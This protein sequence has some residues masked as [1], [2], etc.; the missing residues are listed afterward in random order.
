MGKFLAILAVLL[1][2]IG[3]VGFLRGW[4]EFQTNKE[5][6]KVHADFSVNKDKFKQ[7]KETFKSRSSRNR[8]P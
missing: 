8:R 4:F 5:D 7:D 6:S 2:A 1:V 3:A